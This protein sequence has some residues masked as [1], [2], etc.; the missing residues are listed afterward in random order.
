MLI[1]DIP[2]QELGGKCN[3]KGFF[4]PFGHKVEKCIFIEIYSYI[5]YMLPTIWRAC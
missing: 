2:G 5:G 4:V 1:L 3:L